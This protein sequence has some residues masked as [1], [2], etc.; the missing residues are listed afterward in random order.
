MSTL[1][2]QCTA[3]LNRA[4]A[5][6]FGAVFLLVG[7]IGFAVTGAVGFAGREG[8]AL[9]GLFDVNPLH[10][11]VHLPSGRC[12]SRPRRV[13]RPPLAPRTSSSA[14]FTCSSAWSVC[15]SSPAT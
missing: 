4:V 13:G 8:T 3:S 10:N 15:S 2:T 9:L 1:S 11:I 12:C 14:R 7:L 5:A 6:A